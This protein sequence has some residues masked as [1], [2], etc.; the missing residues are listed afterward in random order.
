[1]S[2]VIIF[3]PAN[4]L[5]HQRS[6]QTCRVSA[7]RLLAVWWMHLHITIKRPF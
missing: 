1:M 2:M 5:H 3:F 6:N 7:A 4:D